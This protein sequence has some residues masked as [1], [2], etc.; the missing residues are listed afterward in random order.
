VKIELLRLPAARWR[1]ESQR[2]PADVRKLAPFVWSS[3]GE[4]IHRPRSAQ[5]HFW[6]DNFAGI[7]GNTATNGIAV[8]LWC[9]MTL[10][11]KRVRFGDAPPIGAS[12]CATCEGRALANGAPDSNALKA[13]PTL[14]FRPR[15]WR[16]WKS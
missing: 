9:G 1:A 11:H 14:T 16:P 15:K 7:K 5:I 12:I 13:S 3:E 10:L 4:Y 8:H 6:G 2:T